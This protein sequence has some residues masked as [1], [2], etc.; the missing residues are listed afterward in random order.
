[1]IA[2][3]FCGV[4]TTRLDKLVESV[5]A[6]RI[7]TQDDIGRKIEK[8]LASTKMSKHIIT[9]VGDQS[10]SYQIDEESV[11]A[12]AATDGIYVIRTTVPTSHLSHF[13]QQLDRMGNT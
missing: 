5:A 3:R 7:K 2:K 9:Y 13:A 8:A 4:A 10:F 1:M 11:R 6:K 12:E